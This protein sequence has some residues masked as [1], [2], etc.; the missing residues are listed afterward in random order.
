MMLEFAGIF[1]AL[2]MA[3]GS[4]FAAMNTMYAAVARRSR[5]IGML[6]TLGFSRFNITLALWFWRCWQGWLGGLRA[7]R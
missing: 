4:S 2:I 6:K 5:E 1:I 7:C 3:V